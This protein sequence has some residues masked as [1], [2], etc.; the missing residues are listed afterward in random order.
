MAYECFK[1]ALRIRGV[2][3]V[4]GWETNRDKVAVILR[5][6]PDIIN[7]AGFLAAFAVQLLEDLGADVTAEGLYDP[8]ADNE[9]ADAFLAKYG[10]T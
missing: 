3:S 6:A 10:G 5:E 4:D 8:E 2:L 1:K 7:Y 9:S